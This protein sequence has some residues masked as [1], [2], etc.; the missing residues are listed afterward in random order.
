MGDVR[1]AETQYRRSI[2]LAPSLAAQKK[3]ADVLLR[4]GQDAEAQTMLRG[5]VVE[6]PFESGPHLELAALLEKTG[7][8]AEAIKEY[9]MALETDP[10]NKESTAALKRLA[11]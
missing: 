11:H 4:T 1:G 5:L 2:E 8:T 10:S 3:L 6:Y 9:R 7:R